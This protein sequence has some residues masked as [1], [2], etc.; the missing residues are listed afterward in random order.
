[1]D[2]EDGVVLDKAGGRRKRRDD[3]GEDHNVSAAANPGPVQTVVPERDA[4]DVGSAADEKEA[5]QT[6]S[7]TGVR[8][9]E[10]QLG[11]LVERARMGEI[12]AFEEIVRLM[13]GPLRSFA[14]R[15]SRYPYLG[16]DAAQEPFLPLW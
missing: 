3:P 8:L 6:T 13:Q 4:E 9:D 2:R 5:E 11:P 12:A 7:R 16:D 14:R 10:E 1:M 15:M